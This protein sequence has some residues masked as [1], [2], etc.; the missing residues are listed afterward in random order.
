MFKTIAETATSEVIEKRSK[1]IADAFYVETV[2][3][4]EEKIKEIRKKY[5]DAKHHCF[6]YSICTNSGSIDRFSDDGEPSGTAGAPML[7]ILNSQNLSNIVV[8]VTRYFGG[9]LLGTGGLLRCYSEATKQ[10]LDSVDK[11]EKDLGLIVKF[12]V[13]YEDL[14]KIKYYFKQ[15]DIKII[16]FNYA[17]NV[18]SSVEITEEKYQKMLKNIKNFNFKVKEQKVVRKSFIALS[19]K[20]EN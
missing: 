9:I 18:E 13:A 8:I 3:E 14:E 15:E 10:A 16:D 19:K 5:Y 2:E 20:E 4:A 1:F 6:A 17:E 12:I 11:A 7:N